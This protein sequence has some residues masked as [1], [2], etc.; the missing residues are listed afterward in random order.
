MGFFSR[1]FKVG[2]DGALGATFG[3]FGGATVGGGTGMLIGMAIGSIIPGL[4]TAVGG[5]VG[6][7]LGSVAGGAL[8]ALGFGGIGALIGLFSDDEEK[9]GVTINNNGGG[10][11]K[12]EEKE[13]ALGGFLKFLSFLGVGAMVWKGYADEHPDMKHKPPGVVNNLFDGIDNMFTPENEPQNKGTQRAVAELVA[14][15]PDQFG[16]EGE[17]GDPTNLAQGPAKKLLDDVAANQGLIDKRDEEIAKAIKDRADTMMANPATSAAMQIITQY[18]ALQESKGS[19][20]SAKE[21]SQL[22]D[23][24]Q[25]PNAPQLTIQEVNHLHTTRQPGG[26][27]SSQGGDGQNLQGNTP[28]E[29]QQINA[30][31]AS[32]REKVNAP[33]DPAGHVVTDKEFSMV[34]QHLNQDQTPQ[35]KISAEE[36]FQL[37]KL[38]QERDL[39]ADMIAHVHEDHGYTPPAATPSPAATQQKGPK[40]AH[41]GR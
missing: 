17:R 22:M 15:H 31:I 34:M 25:D 26:N 6:G 40:P 28:E 10:N 12:G 41:E 33:L 24:A 18:A 2:A 29:T 37:L 35:G 14:K 30:A 3:G 21:L 27:L 7:L 19:H 16:P 20:I 39:T 8:G 11:G 9:N 5:V 1:M 23:R 4:G 13:S 36:T 38:A 32:V